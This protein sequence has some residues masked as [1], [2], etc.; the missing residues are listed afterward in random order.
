M[1]DL[2]VTS[3]QE[4]LLTRYLGR[5]IHFSDRLPSTMDEALR[6]AKQGAPEGTVVLTDE[7]TKGRGRFQRVWLS[8]KGQSLLLSIIFRPSLDTLP[9]L[10]MATSLAVVLSVKRETSL[11]CSIKWPNDVLL[12]GRKVCGILTEVHFKGTGPEFAIVGLGLNVSLNPHEHPEIST[13]ATSLAHELGTTVSRPHLLVCFLRELEDLY[14]A[15]KG[16][17]VLHVE[18]RRHLETLGKHIRVQVGEQ[19]EEG[20][21]VDITETGGLLL[22]RPDGSLLN[23]TEGEVTLRT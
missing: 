21:A 4:L 15:A 2:S 20:E 13:L 22:R 7:Q 3:I 9:K 12:N 19:V 8:P 5:P 23:L 17:Q 10:N 11:E 14:E 18:W 6:L 16:G 1:P